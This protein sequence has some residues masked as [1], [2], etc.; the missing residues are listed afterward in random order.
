MVKARDM[1]KDD[2]THR[3]FYLH[4][5]RLR[6]IHLSLAGGMLLIGVLVSSLQ[7]EPVVNF[8]VGDS[9]LIYLVPVAALAGYFLGLYI[10]RRL[11]QVLD[12]RQELSIRLSRYQTASLLQY[13]CL[14]APAL[15]ALYAYIQNGYLFYAAIAAFMLIYFCAQWPTALKIIRNVPLTSREKAILERPGQSGS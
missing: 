10:F 14:E 2:A 8:P 6:I 11:L 9:T 1:N 13:S 15:L 7:K 5:Q 3:T 12:A 4:L